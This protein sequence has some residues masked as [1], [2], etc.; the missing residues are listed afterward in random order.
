MF[1]L[2]SALYAEC[3]Y[4]VALYMQSVLIVQCFICTV[5]VYVVLYVQSVLIV[6]LICKVSLLFALY[7]KCP[8]YVLDM[9]SVLMMCF[10]CKVS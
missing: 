9:Q 7:A 3:P 10:V 8:Y 2:C 4:Y 1:L 5:S 6:C